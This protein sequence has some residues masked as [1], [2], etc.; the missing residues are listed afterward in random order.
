VL[1]VGKQVMSVTYELIERPAIA[2]QSYRVWLKSV[3]R[4]D[5]RTIG[6]GD[7]YG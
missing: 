4:T 3:E 1:Y 2:A 5:G 7:Y 6:S